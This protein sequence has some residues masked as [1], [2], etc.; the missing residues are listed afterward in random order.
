MRGPGV[1]PE[2]VRPPPVGGPRMASGPGLVGQT[3]R[4]AP[5]S[6]GDDGRLRGN[7]GDLTS[8]V[9]MRNT[10]APTQ[11]TVVLPRRSHDDRVPA[12]TRRGGAMASIGA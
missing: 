9:T 8:G 6:V 7:P 12:P 11:R 10:G 2:G 3:A 1:K 5:G 4:P